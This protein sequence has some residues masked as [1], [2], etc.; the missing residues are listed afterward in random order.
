[1]KPRFISEYYFKPI[2]GVI[3]DPRSFF[4]SIHKENGKTLIKALGVVVVSSAIS[5]LAGTLVSVKIKPV[6]V[7]FI[8]FGNALGMVFIS[9]GLGY[10][11]AKIVSGQSLKMV[12]FFNIYAFSFSATLLFSWI[13][14]SLWI[15]EPWKWWLIG[16]GLINGAGI[17]F[18]RTL[19]IILLSITVMIVSFW[20]LMKII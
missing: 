6:M 12:P 20:L 1:M 7:Y 15:T 19:M 13:P 16:T 17:E 2:A 18:R 8:F 11:F 9:S 3:Q 10:L 4:Y 14:Y 5:A